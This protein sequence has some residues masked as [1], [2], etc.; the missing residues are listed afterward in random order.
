MLSST[1]ANALAQDSANT[2]HVHPSATR[3]ADRRSSTTL[4]TPVHSANKCHVLP[5]T[6]SSHRSHTAW[7]GVRAA[8]VRGTLRASTCEGT[9]FLI[10]RPTIL[11]AQA[12]TNQQL[13]GHMFYDFICL[14]FPVGNPRIDRP[15]LLEVFFP[16]QNTNNRIVS[17]TLLATTDVWGWCVNAPPRRRRVLV[18]T[19]KKTASVHHE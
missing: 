16:H 18:T 5:S 1:R 7:A 8:W 4:S 9:L 15:L 13:E 6:F 2:C 11:E 3:V 12:F 10:M 17:T 14:P 19:T